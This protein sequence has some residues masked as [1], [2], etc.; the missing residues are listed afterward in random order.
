M[1]F[2]EELRSQSI[3]V[4]GA[5]VTGSALCTF[6]LSRGITPAVIDEKATSVAGIEVL[7]ELPHDIHLA[8]LSPGWKPT[9]SIVATLQSRGIPILSEIDFAWRV[10]NEIAPDQKWIAL[11]GTNGKTTTIQ[12]VNSIFE[13]ARVNGI[14]CG[15]VGDTVIEALSAQKPYD[16]LALELSSFQ[17]EWSKEARYEAV[18][19]LN[20]AE[21]HIDWH[22]TFDNYAN[23]KMRLLE[24][25]EIAILNADDPEIALRSTAWSGRKVF[26]S[27]ETPAPAELGLVENLLVDR[28][29]I[30]DPSQAE[31][32]AE[33]HDIQPT[34][35]HN[36][37]NALA[38]AGLTRA[39]GI[40]HNDIKKGLAAFKVDHH[41]IEVVLSKDE[42]TWVND[43]KA[44]NPHAAIAS[45]L[46]HEKVV[47]IA[48]GLAKGAS[49]DQ[50]VKRAKP[51]LSAAI[52]IGADRELIEAALKEHAPDV[53]RIL[54][55]N[56]ESSEAL[57]EKIV[58]EAMKVASK[59][60]AVLL[61]PACASMDQFI[62]YSHRGNL[63]AD[64]VRKIVGA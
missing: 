60:D 34:V 64:A 30:S 19:I 5:G 1:S 24:A 38:A 2:L 18:A 21:D 26:Y 37:S 43:S 32:I 41:R 36:V 31:A 47:W 53:P 22:E 62:S 46:S 39:I 17:I 51:R 63:F 48:G 56:H 59:G 61:A 14:A 33:L 8:I 52:L 3:T 11:T 20:I 55:D 7:R 58:S 44:T 15:N 35:P 57:M 23:A 6:L 54:I 49:M 9:H 45:I 12:M 16:I 13:S 27:L 42:I 28:A 10:K 29:F 50:L 40:S 4:V 25:T